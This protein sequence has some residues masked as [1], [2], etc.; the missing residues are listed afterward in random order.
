MQ[1]EGITENFD[2][3]SD[4]ENNG[5]FDYENLINIENIGCIVCFKVRDVDEDYYG[6]T[7]CKNCEL[8]KVCAVTIIT[9]SKNKKLKNK[10]PVCSKKKLW[11][12]NLKSNELLLPPTILEGDIER[13]ILIFERRS[14]L[15]RNKCN[16]LKIICVIIFSMVMSFLIYM[17]YIGTKF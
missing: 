15:V 3:D 8:C 14:F 4:L 13:R 2:N 17:I 1:E 11:C 12:R 6:C 5:V 9:Q 7:R 16:D 10:C